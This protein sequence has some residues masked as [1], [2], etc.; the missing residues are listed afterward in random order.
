M[1]IEDIEFKT[2]QMWIQIY[3]LSLDMINEQNAQRIE[4][5]LD[6]CISAESALIMKQRSYLRLKVDISVKEP[7]KTGF[8]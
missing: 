5:S 4:N 2:M 6:R 7:L 1:C 8:W 3:G